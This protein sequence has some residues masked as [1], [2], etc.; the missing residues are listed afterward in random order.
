MAEDFFVVVIYNLF[1]SNQEYIF[2]SNKRPLG[3]KGETFRVSL[4]TQGL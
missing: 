1:L 3:L 4:C 2:V